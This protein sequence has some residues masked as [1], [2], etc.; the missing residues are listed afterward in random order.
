[1]SS[2]FTIIFP[3][4]FATQKKQQTIQYLTNRQARIIVSIKQ[5]RLILHFFLTLRHH[6]TF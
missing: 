2:L 3:F 6:G 1:M 4:I 5:R